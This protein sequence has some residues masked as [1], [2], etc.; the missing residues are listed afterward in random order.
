MTD[1]HVGVMARVESAP[2]AVTVLNGYS[3]IGNEATVRAGCRLAGTVVYPR[4]TVPAATVTPVGTTFV[5]ATDFIG[6]ASA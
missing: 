6:E 4:L 1:T 2:A 5:V 3:A